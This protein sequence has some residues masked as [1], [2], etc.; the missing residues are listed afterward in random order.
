MFFL[1]FIEIL[2]SAN[3][4]GRHIWNG[5]F[6]DSL[7]FACVIIKLSSA[8]QKL[9]FQQIYSLF[10]GW[11]LISQTQYRNMGKGN[12]PCKVKNFAIHKSLGR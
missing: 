3:F 1:F 9:L 7:F 2:L 8:L 4:A 6:F 11:L 10:L 5:G 12:T